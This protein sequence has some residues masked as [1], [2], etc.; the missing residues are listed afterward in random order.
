MLAAEAEQS[1]RVKRFRA[2][3][4]R[5]V[6]ERDGISFKVN[7]GCVEAKVEDLRFVALEYTASKKRRGMPLVV[8][9]GRCPSCG[10]ET[11]S[12]PFYSLAGLGKMLENFEPISAH[13]CP[14]RQ[15]SKSDE[16]RGAVSRDAS[17]DY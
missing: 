15:R 2:E 17:K 8:L 9:L 16:W 10:V 11:I 6:G 1:R 4:H 13:F 12:E 5:I 3:L 14:S 7:G